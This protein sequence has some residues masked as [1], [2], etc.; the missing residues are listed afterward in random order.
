MKRPFLAGLFFCLV[1]VFVLACGGGGGGG[2]GGSDEPSSTTRTYHL[3]PDGCFI[4]GY[5]V[6][7]SLSGSSNQGETITGSYSIATRANVEVDGKQAIHQETYITMNIVNAG[8]LSD[9]EHA[10]EPG[11]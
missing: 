8:T 3:Y 7:F 11:A 6:T 5:R 1:S 2:G 4:P 9:I 10:E